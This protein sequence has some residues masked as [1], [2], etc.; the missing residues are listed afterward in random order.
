M[1]WTWD[2]SSAVKGPN[3]I[4]PALS[5]TWFTDWGSTDFNWSQSVSAVDD[6]E[7]TLL[8]LG[9]EF[10]L[11]NATVLQLRGGQQRTGSDFDLNIAN[12]ALLISW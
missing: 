5:T 8:S 11:S 4:A 12:A 10:D 9:V 6:A 2:S 3:S 7:S 1:A